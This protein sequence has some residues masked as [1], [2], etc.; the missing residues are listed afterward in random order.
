VRLEQTTLESCDNV[1]MTLTPGWLR[2]RCQVDIDAAK[3]EGAD[4]CGEGAGCEGRHI[5]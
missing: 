5:M 4:T 2:C 1:D 3:A